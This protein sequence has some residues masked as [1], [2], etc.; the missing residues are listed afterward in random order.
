[1][2]GFQ[3]STYGR[4]WVSTEARTPARPV[5]QARESGSFL[6][7]PARA[8]APLA[9]ERSFAALRTVRVESPFGNCIPGAR[10][11]ASGA[12]LEAETLTSGDG[13]ASLPLAVTKRTK[14]LTL[15][16]DG[17]GVQPKTVKLSVKLRK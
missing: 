5:A 9:P 10:V 17:A 15:T 7:Q 1:M 8:A 6:R 13:V 11:R 16:V 14:R 12:D 2:A 3:V 4:V